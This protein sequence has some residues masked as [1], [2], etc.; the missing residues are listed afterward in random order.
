MHSIGPRYRRPKALTRGRPVRP[1]SAVEECAVIGVP[2]GVGG[3]EG[4]LL[5]HLRVQQDDAT[6][7]DL[8]IGDC[9]RAV[10]EGIPNRLVA[11][12]SQMSLSTFCL[13]HQDVEAAWRSKAKIWAGS[14]RIVKSGSTNALRIRPSASIT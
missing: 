14:S 11:G 1:R 4:A 7:F 2:G 10:G 13:P 8:L 5:W 6:V 12:L 9:E 3:Y